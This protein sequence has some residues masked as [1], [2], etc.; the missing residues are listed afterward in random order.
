MHLNDSNS[1][2]YRDYLMLLIVT[3]SENWQ[4]NSS[5]SATFVLNK[6]LFDFEGRSVKKPDSCNGVVLF[7]GGI[8]SVESIFSSF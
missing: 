1:F 4:E 7:I 6:T 3:C 5:K 8:L 2:P